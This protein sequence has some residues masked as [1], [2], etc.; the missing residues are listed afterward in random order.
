MRMSIIV[1]AAVVVCLLAAPLTLGQA[2]NPLAST[3]QAGN[4]RSGYGQ[5]GYGQ[6]PYGGTTGNIED[7][8]NGLTE[9]FRLSLKN[10]DAAAYEKLVADDFIS[11]GTAGRSFTKSQI[12]ESLKSGKLTYEQHDYSNRKIRLFGDTAIVNCTLDQKARFG[13]RELVGQYL[14]A[15]VWVKR[16]GQ[17]QLVSWQ[18][19]PVVKQT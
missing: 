12:I 18:A 17:W 3:S 5:G 14:L 9:Q 7:T 11:I 15:L 2:G 16:N 6:T 1:L 8:I 19:T 13:D 10:M 4:D